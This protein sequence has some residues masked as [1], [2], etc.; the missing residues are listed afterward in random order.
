MLG[1]KLTEHFKHRLVLWRQRN[2][3]KLPESII[4]YCDGVSES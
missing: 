4:I 1:D 3:N 2:Q